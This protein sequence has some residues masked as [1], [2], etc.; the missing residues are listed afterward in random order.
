MSTRVSSTNLEEAAKEIQAAWSH[1]KDYWR[2]AKALE[3]ERT[4][5]EKLPHLVSQARTVMEEID[6]VLRK[7]RSDCE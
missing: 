6:S 4:Y 2:D 1:T 5:L 7:M 3:F